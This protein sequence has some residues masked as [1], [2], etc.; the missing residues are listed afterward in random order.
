MAGAGSLRQDFAQGHFIGRSIGC[1]DDAVALGI[2]GAAGARGAD[3]F[4]GADRHFARDRL[5]GRA[6]TDDCRPLTGIVRAQPPS[7]DRERQNAAYA[8]ITVSGAPS[9][10]GNARPAGVLAWQLRG[11]AIRSARALSPASLAGG[12][13]ECDAAPPC[14]AARNLIS[15]QFSG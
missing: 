1:L 9:G 10:A 3:A 14:E 4:R 2:A 12:S 5:R 13:G 6:G 15:V 8:G 7:V 11:G